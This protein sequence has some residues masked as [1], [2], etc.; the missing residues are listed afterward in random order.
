MKVPNK[1]ADSGTEA[2]II[3]TS[4]YLSKCA[5]LELSEYHNQDCAM[6]TEAFPLAPLAPNVLAQPQSPRLQERKEEPRE[7]ARL[8][9]SKMMED[10]CRIEG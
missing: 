5:K 8:G 7:R 4:T 10:F 3:L 2:D 6:A 1:V 9:W